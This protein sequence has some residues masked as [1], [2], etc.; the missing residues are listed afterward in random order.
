MTLTWDPNLRKWL[1]TEACV[2]DQPMSPSGS[3]PMPIL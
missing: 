2:Y 3:V 1:I